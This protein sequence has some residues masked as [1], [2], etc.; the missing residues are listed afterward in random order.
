M[1]IKETTVK[2]TVLNF[3]RVAVENGPGLSQH[4]EY[5]VLGMLITAP[6]GH[7]SGAVPM[8]IN[9]QPLLVLLPLS[10]RGSCMTMF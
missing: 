8:C 10:Q 2:A 7:M 9:F 4:E 1:G 3:L 6:K 5:E